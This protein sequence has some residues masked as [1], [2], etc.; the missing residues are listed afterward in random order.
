MKKKTLVM[1]VAI[2]A[3]M[4]A[5]CQFNKFGLAPDHETSCEDGE[6]ND[7]DGL[8][9]CDD[10]D[11]NLDLACQINDCGNGTLDASEVCDGGYGCQS[12]C[13]CQNPTWISNDVGGCLDP[14]LC[15]N[16]VEDPGEQCDG[17][18]DCLE[19]CT[20]PVGM[21]PDDLTG[22]RELCG[23]LIV[24]P[25]EA[26][27]D[28]NNMS[29]DG[30][31]ADCLS[32]ESCGNGVVDSGETCDEGGET[33]ECDGD[34]TQSS[35]GDG[36]LNTT[37]GEACDGGGESASCNDDCTPHV[38]GD[39]NVNETAGEQCDDSGESSTCD[40]DC[41][42][43][44][45]GDGV[46]NVTAGEV[47]DDGNTDSGD[48]CSSNCLSDETCGNG[49]TDV[50]EV[51]DDGNTTSGDGCSA[52]CLSDE[53]CGNGILD[54]NEAC[55]GGIDCLNCLCPEGKGSDGTGGCQVDASTCGDG[56]DNDLDGDMDCDDTDCGVITVFLNSGGN[57][58]VETAVDSQ[59]QGGP[60]GWT[61]TIIIDSL[62][63][64][65][66]IYVYARASDADNEDGFLYWEDPNSFPH[67]DLFTTAGT[68][69]T[70]H[71]VG[72]GENK[73]TNYFIQCQ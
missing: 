15:G 73:W 53:T 57:V 54:A 62:D 66:R 14:N 48:G 40:D 29:G 27:D 8:I 67:P 43:V 35:C 71:S 22:C 70:S 11:C 39:G 49:I 69:A 38:C 24:D 10:A 51:C 65:A 33:A 12:D 36:F 64:W 20:C 19:D 18:N 25:G 68:P 23:N 32:D 58:Y 55:D 42:A 37:A 60:L 21:E 56:I 26:C 45:C 34:C 59:L 28:G 63:Q 61:A 46:E 52:D 4:L 7:N 50:N 17:G 9:D 44:Q 16:G 31:S 2:F 1:V 13:T 5:G 6:D 47:C 3:L 41:T 72:Y 30:C